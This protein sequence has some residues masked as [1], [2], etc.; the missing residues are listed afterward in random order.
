MV[1][2][3]GN[4]WYLNAITLVEQ[5]T[6][7]RLPKRFISVNL[8]D[9]PEDSVCQKLAAGSNFL[10]RSD[11]WLYRKLPGAV[12][13]ENTVYMLV[14][15]KSESKRAIAYKLQPYTLVDNGDMIMM[16]KESKAVKWSQ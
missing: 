4:E 2:Y 10:V 16:Y 5:E 15:T 14:F 12:D 1:P 13:R 3:R 8:F 9:N 7:R 11:D 6:R